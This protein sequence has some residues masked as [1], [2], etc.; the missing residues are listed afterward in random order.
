[1]KIGEFTKKDYPVTAC[2]SEKEVSQLFR[3]GLLQIKACKAEL[4]SLAAEKDAKEA[5]R[6]IGSFL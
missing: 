5:E 2:S 1:M 6:L 4:I 3:R